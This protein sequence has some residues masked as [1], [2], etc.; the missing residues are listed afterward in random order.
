MTTE[1]PRLLVL[2]DGD[3]NFYLISDD[4]IHASRVP[5]EN[6][7]EVQQALDS[8]VA[9]FFFNNQAFQNAF[10]TVNQGNTANNTNVLIG[11]LVGGSQTALSFQ[12]NAANVGTSQNA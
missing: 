5:E 9:G 3:G 1:S 10:T 8:D 2:R 12:S 7:A 6:W 11:A 4:V